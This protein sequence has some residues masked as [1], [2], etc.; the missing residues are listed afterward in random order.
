MVEVDGG[1][2]R[3]GM[4]EQ[5]SINYS[6]CLYYLIDVLLTKPSCDLVIHHTSNVNNLCV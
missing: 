2:G 1:R 5:S 4:Q 3:W 6:A